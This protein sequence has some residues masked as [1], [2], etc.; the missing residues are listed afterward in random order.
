MPYAAAAILA[1]VTGVS[2]NLAAIAA[3]GFVVARSLYSVFY[4]SDLPT[5]RSFVFGLGTLSTITLFILSVLK[6][7]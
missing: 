3:I 6:I 7:Q 1:I 2:S 5:A 4:I